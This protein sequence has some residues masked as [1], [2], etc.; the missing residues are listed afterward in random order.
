MFKNVLS[1]TYIIHCVIC[2]LYLNII[3]FKPYVLKLNILLFFYSFNTFALI[4]LCNALVFDWNVQQS[5]G[6]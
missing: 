6:G 5:S 3:Y 4:I 2:I 1:V